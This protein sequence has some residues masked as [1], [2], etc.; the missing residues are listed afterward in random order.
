MWGLVDL[1]V[2]GGGVDCKCANVQMCKL[3]VA[4]YLNCNPDL[5]TG[6]VQYWSMSSS[7]WV[8]GNVAPGLE[9]RVKGKCERAARPLKGF[10]Q[11]DYPQIELEEHYRN[12]WW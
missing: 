9:W 3:V 10:H 12:E 1:D 7:S 4:T 5:L 2:E 8:G 6:G 11:S